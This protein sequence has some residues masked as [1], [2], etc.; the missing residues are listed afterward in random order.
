MIYFDP[1][2]DPPMWPYRAEKDKYIFGT[3]TTSSLSSFQDGVFP[4]RNMH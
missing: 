3:M 1:A 4:L 2:L